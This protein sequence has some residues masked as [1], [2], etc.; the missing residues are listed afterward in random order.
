VNVLVRGLLVSL[1]AGVAASGVMAAGWDDARAVTKEEIIL[2]LQGEQRLGYALDAPANSTRLHA[3]VLL[4]LAAAAQAADPERR[5]LRVGHEAYFRAFLQVTGH[6]PASAPKFMSVAH[7]HGEDFLIDYRLENVVAG[8]RSGKAPNRALT[9]RAG[10]PAA[11]GSPSSYSYEDTT[12]DPHTEVA[13]AQLNGYRILDFGDA[14]VYDDMYGITGRVTSG[15]L[16][17]IFKV[18]GNADGVQTRLAFA[19]DGTQLQRTTARKMLTATQTVTIS[20]DGK[21]LP[22]VPGNRPDLAALEK[23]LVELDFNLIYPPRDPR[24]MPFRR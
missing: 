4:G 1:G 11:P 23:R 5:P 17:V 14:I 3:A 9:V 18:L 6:T 16:A 19:Q 8:V 21:V 15:V 7:C 2:A 22:G 13:H 10:W 20:P 24:P 12:T